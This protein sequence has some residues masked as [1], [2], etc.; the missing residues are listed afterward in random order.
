MPDLIHK[1]PDKGRACFF[2]FFGKL[3]Y[4]NTSEI[5]FGGAMCEQDNC[6]VLEMCLQ[7]IAKC[8]EGSD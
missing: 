5:P 7:Q 6:D 3:F 8:R 1:D 2:F 4:Q